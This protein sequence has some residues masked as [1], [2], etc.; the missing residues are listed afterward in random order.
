MLSSVHHWVRARLG[1]VWGSVLVL[2]PFVYASVVFRS[3]RNE[4]LESVRGDSKFGL[5]FTS[6]SIWFGFCWG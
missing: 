6:V 5:R 1:A 2:V 3:F 4:D